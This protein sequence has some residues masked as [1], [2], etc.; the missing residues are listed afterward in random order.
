M[1]GTTSYQEH[2]PT[3]KDTL[4]DIWWN[5]AAQ[6]AIEQPHNFLSVSFACIFA[7]KKF[8][9]TFAFDNIFTLDFLCKFFSAYNAKINRERFIR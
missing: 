1:S 2:Y 7:A 8:Y 9:K 5:F 4:D 3:F 6:G